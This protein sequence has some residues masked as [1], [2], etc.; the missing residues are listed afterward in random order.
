MRGNSP[1]DSPAFPT[2]EFAEHRRQ[3]KRRLV[4]DYRRVNSRTLRAVY[5]VRR[6]DDI[7]SLQAPSMFPLVDDPP[8][9]ATGGGDAAP[10]PVAEVDAT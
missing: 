2:K 6:A 10:P 4:V 3:R 9:D 1:W 8:S 5:F 7:K